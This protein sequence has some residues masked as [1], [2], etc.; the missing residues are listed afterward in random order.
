MLKFTPKISATKQEV[1]SS[2]SRITAVCHLLRYSY[3]FISEDT[4]ECDFSEHNELQRELQGRLHHINDGA[5]A[6]W[7]K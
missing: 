4:E 7:K 2:Q 6:P 5:N 1:I 3:T